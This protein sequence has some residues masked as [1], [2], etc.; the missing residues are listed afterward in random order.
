MERDLGS[1]T[2]HRGPGQASAIGSATFGGYIDLAS[3][4]LSSTRGATVY[5]MVGGY[6][7]RLYD[8]E[9]QTGNLGVLGGGRGLIDLSGEDARGATSNTDTQR[10]NA[11]LKLEQ[12]LGEN[13]VVTFLT[14]VDKNV[15][16]TPM[17][18]RSPTSGCSAPTTP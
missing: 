6:S 12:P 3:P 8:I 17:A 11:F 1:I 16:H 7:T 14:N 5:S 13:T 4:N 18:R 15:T 9:A 2:I 10:R